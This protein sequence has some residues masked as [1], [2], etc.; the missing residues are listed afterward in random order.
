[1]SQDLRE[2]FS[3]YDELSLTEKFF[4]RTC[5]YLPPKTAKALTDQPELRS[6][7]ASVDLL[8]NSLGA[9][10]V[11][12]IQGKTVLDVGCGNGEYA[13]AIATLGAAGVTGI[14]L[15]EPNGLYRPLAEAAGVAQKVKIEVQDIQAI[16][17]NSCDTVFSHDS[18][19]HF[20]DPDNMLSEM[21]RVC[22]PSGRIYIKFGP[23][24]K[25]PYGRHMSG[26][27]RKDRPWVHLIFSERTIMRVHSVY[28]NS[29]TLYEHYADKRGGLN[30]MTL[31]K[32]DGVLAR[33][34]HQATELEYRLMP[35]RDQI[36]GIAK[37]ALFREYLCPAVMVALEKRSVAVV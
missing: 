3:K 9:G 19:E 2:Y 36:A 12:W 15:L 27:I 14:D 4:L 1:M 20:D 35:I 11:E 28:H 16:P 33:H 25:S 34:A 5:C 30:Q 13:V 18:F 29:D 17:S 10:F 21:I 37:H 26:T 22:R 23:A 32:F 31:R 8:N 7:Q 24:W 6:N